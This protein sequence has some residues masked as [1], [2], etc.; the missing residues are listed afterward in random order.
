L[1]SKFIVRTDQK[2]L[3]FLLDQTISTSAQQKWLVKL[4]GYDYEIE[5]KRGR[6]NSVA[7]ALS[8]IEGPKSLMAISHPIPH[9]LEPIQ[10]ELQAL[11]ERIQEGEAVGPWKYKEGLI[12]FKERIYLLSTSSLIHPIIAEI[13]GSTHKGF[14]KTMK[15]LRAVFYWPKMKESI[16]AFIR[17]CDVCQ[18]HKTE[19]T[20]PSGL[21]QPLPIPT[22]VWA[23]VSMDFIDRLPKSHGKST[24]LVL[25]D[26]L[27]KYGHF[28]PISH[29]YTAPQ[30]ARVYFDN[31]FKL[32]GMPESIVCDRD[33]TFTS[34]FWTE[35]FS[36]HGTKFNFSSAYHPQTDGQT[37]V[38]NRTVE[39]YLRC[40]TSSQPKEW[41]TWLPWVE[42]CY[43]TSTHSA[44][45]LT[46]FELVYGRSPPTL[47]SYVNGTTL[48]E[49]VEKI[50]VKRDQ[51]LKEARNRLIQAQN[52]MTQIYN[53]HHKEKQFNVGD[54]VYLK[55][56]PYRQSSVEFRSN[57]KLSAK[58]Y[59]PFKILKKIG[60]VAYLLDLPKD[61]KLHHVFHISVLKQ[62]VGTA[63]PT[64]IELPVVPD[65]PIQPQSILEQRMRKGAMEI[66]VHW[67]GFSPADASW[68]NKDDFISRFPNFVLKDKDTSK[69]GGML[70]S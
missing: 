45:N 24:I 64:E 27:T 25:V 6:E 21:L 66:L 39:M 49:A 1:G 59:G 52:R 19:T 16:K 42:Y 60:S 41:V 9:W 31:I 36:L 62:H 28:I 23:E 15:R 29:P 63:E 56:Q 48:V 44:H 30:V 11:V 61:S 8:R 58:Y 22:K 46:P 70:Q 18:R 13:H 68:E 12:F 67:M 35:L 37:E 14:F 10:N 69:E 33:P 3:K 47:L 53:K 57:A 51:L 38:L 4:L 54:W 55:L 65:S 32:H 26:R 17:Q 50:L 5:Y 7:D 20:M 2:S 43:N 40:L 34:R